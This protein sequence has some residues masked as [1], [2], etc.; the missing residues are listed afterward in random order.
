MN[1]KIFIC[2]LT[3]IATTLVASADIVDDVRTRIA[4]MTAELPMRRKHSE[5]LWNYDIVFATNVSYCALAATVSNDWRN[6][7]ANLALCATN[8]FERL[9]VLGVRDRFGADF[10]MD[11][12]DELVTMKTNDL[13]TAKEFSWARSTEVPELERYLER[14][15]QKPR[16]RTLVGRFK[17]AEP[18]NPRWDDVLSGA[19]YT[20]YLDEVSAGLWGENPPR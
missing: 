20:N 11:F 14:R 6:A 8:Q 1:S 7:L 13:I 17:I 3:L 5:M 15:Y 4:L 18:E 2:A 9:L 10:Y 12:M 19:A 16:V